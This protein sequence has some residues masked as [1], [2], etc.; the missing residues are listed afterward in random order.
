MSSEA[1]FKS[2]RY[3]PRSN[4]PM[5]CNAISGE[6]RVL[7]CCFKNGDDMTKLYFIYNL[8]VFITLYSL[9]DR[10]LLLWRENPVQGLHLSKY[11]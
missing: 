2:R 5:P 10:W 1:I 9:G 7:H 8:Q 6:T 11:V 4:W 3:T